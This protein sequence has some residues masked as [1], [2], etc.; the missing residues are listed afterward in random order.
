MWARHLCGRGEKDGEGKQ[1][2][3]D[4]G[5]RSMS[6]E[7]ESEG[8]WSQKFKKIGGRN[9]SGHRTRFSRS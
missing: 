1:S 2:L 3:E 7:K 8:D 9:V 5:V 4:P 6:R